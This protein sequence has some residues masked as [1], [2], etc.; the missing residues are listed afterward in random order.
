MTGPPSK[1]K[2]PPK[3][4]KG[5][6]IGEGTY[7]WVYHARSKDTGFRFALKQFKG[8]REG[9]GLSPTAIR[10][11]M[12]LR[13]L[14]HENIVRLDSVHINRAEPS[15]WLAFDYADHDLFEMIRYHREH[16]DNRKENPTGEHKRG[17]LAHAC[18]HA[19]R[20]AC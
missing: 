1:F 15:L 6:K 7:G 8:G 18:M 12:L 10:E 5:E 16:R 4:E 17:D 11:I 19:C 3:F 13:E 2:F 14:N 20:R 9:E